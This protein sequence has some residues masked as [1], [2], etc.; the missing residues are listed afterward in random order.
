MCFFR[1]KE[2]EQKAWIA[3]WYFLGMVLGWLSFGTWMYD[4]AADNFVH[5]NNCLT[6]LY[7]LM[8]A[9]NCVIDSCCQFFICAT[10]ASKKDDAEYC[11]RER[12]ILVQL[13]RVPMHIAA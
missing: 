13:L 2:D 12:Q 1:W 4:V 7:S 11:G 9:F 8:L 3:R 10:Y 5:Y 6:A